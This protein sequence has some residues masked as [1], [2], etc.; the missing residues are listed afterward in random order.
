MRKLSLDLD[1]LIVE[2]FATDPE[3]MGGQGTVK[4][5][6]NSPPFTVLEPTVCEDASCKWTQC[7]NLSCFAQCGSGGATLGGDTCT[8]ACRLTPPEIE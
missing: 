8:V 1:T 4:G 2:S 6:S 5:H 3:A 7:N